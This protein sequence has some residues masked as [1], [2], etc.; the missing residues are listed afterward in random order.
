M[1]PSS[2]IDAL[3]SNRDRCYFLGHRCTYDKIS[4]FLSTSLKPAQCNKIMKVNSVF[5]HLLH[6]YLHQDWTRWLLITLSL[7]YCRDSSKFTVLIVVSHLFFSGIRVGSF[8]FGGAIK[9][10]FGGGAQ[11]FRIA[12]NRDVSNGLLPHPFTHWLAPLTHSL[13]PPCLLTYPLP[14]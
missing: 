11:W 2:S 8:L 4:L 9:D 3:I 6:L 12:K 1:I 13:T 10:G 7:S 14:S 5:H